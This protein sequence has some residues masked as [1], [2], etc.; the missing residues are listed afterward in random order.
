MQ[1]QGQFLM[2]IDNARSLTIKSGAELTI[3]GN[4]EA[5]GQTDITAYPVGLRV[6]IGMQN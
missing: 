1:K 5:N 2:L 3:S 4:F 6:L